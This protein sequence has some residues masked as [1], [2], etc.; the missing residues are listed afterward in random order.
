MNSFRSLLF[1]SLMILIVPS[2]VACSRMGPNFAHDYFALN[3]PDDLGGFTLFQVECSEPDES[4]PITFALRPIHDGYLSFGPDEKGAHS[5]WTDYIE[6]RF[7]N[8]APIVTKDPD[9]VAMHFDAP[10]YFDAG[11]KD[12]VRVYS[13]KIMYG[14]NA[15]EDL[16]EHVIMYNISSHSNFNAS[17][18]DLRYLGKVVPGDKIRDYFKVGGAIHGTE[19]YLTFDSIPNDMPD[20]FTLTIEIPVELNESWRNI[21]PSYMFVSRLWKAPLKTCTYKVSTVIKRR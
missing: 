6:E 20:E 12:E 9:F 7:M 16:S 18:P 5:Y 17:Y 11:V 10:A 8:L 4:H 1:T 14:L 15:G 21:M 19:D 13:D 2:F 3:S